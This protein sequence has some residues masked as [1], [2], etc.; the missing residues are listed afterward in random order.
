[1]LA[2]ALALALTTLAAVGCGKGGPSPTATYKVAYEAMKNKDV[3][4]FKKVITKKDL[5][6][7]EET[8]KK[9]NKSS[10][11]MLK[12]LMNAIPTPKS[13]DS[14]DE[15]IS[16]DTATLQVKNEKDEWDTINF[17][18]EDGDWKMK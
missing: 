14:K 5:Q 9:A 2:L 16:G 8:A 4:A 3:A 10:D 18:K 7:I 17:V 11:E 15:K 12:D 13:G 6:D 1:M